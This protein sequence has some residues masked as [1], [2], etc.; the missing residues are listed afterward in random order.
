MKRTSFQQFWQSDPARLYVQHGAAIS[1]VMASA[2][3][4]NARSPDPLIAPESWPLTAMW[5]SCAVTGFGIIL[6]AL[7]SEPEFDDSL[8]RG[9]TLQRYRVRLAVP[10][11][12]LMLGLMG[13]VFQP[14]SASAP[15]LWATPVAY[16]LLC[17]I[18]WSVAYDA[19]TQRLVDEDSRLHGGEQARAHRSRYEELIAPRGAEAPAAQRAVPVPCSLWTVLGGGVFYIALVPASAAVIWWAGS[20]LAV[21]PTVLRFCGVLLLSMPAALTMLVIASAIRYLRARIDLLM[22]CVLGG[23]YVSVTLIVGLSASAVIVPRF[24]GLWLVVQVAVSFGVAGLLYFF[25]ALAARAS[26]PS[27]RT[28]LAADWHR[29]AARN[30]ALASG[31]NETGV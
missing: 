23:I 8:S 15:I 22:N 3:F 14:L 24:G 10:G 11:I 2:V 19:D 6:S 25:N 9:R 17:A 27:W 29:A 18:H 5:F 26:R 16:A 1:V 31:P 12:I 4:M 13:A 21:S 30:D 7:M 20:V 28:P